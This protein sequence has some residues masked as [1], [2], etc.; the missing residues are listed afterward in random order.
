MKCRWHWRM[1]YSCSISPFTTYIACVPQLLH[2]LPPRFTFFL[3]LVCTVSSASCP[4]PESLGIRGQRHVKA[5]RQKV[6]KVFFSGHWGELKRLQRSVTKTGSCWVL[7]SLL[8]WQT[9]THPLVHT[10][11]N[12]HTWSSCHT[13]NDMYECGTFR[14]NDVKKKEKQTKATFHLYVPFPCLPTQACAFKGKQRSDQSP[15]DSLMYNSLFNKCGW[16][17]LQKIF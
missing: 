13:H 16:S 5:I 15:Q 14:E 10:Q 8:H 7:H 9:Q 6:S 1:E 2:I 4:P 11:T 12:R 3:T 17:L